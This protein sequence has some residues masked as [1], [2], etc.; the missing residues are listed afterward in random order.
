MTAAAIGAEEELFT[1][2]WLSTSNR[3]ILTIFRVCIA[4]DA[5]I[6]HDD[7]EVVW[8]RFMSLQELDGMMREGKPFV[9]G[10]LKAWQEAQARAIPN[11]Y[12][13]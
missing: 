5:V 12:L 4:S 13:K 2:T 9:P 11:K 10:G 6:E 1:L 3:V 7:G 8:G